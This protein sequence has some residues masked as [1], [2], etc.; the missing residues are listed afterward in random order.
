MA[1]QHAFD[2]SFFSLSLAFHF[3]MYIGIPGK[4]NSTRETSNGRSA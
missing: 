3:Y 2:S 4:K 1:N